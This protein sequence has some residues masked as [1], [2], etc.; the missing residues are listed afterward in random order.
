MAG[1]LP[2]RSSSLS[3]VS[4]SLAPGQS[5]ELEEVLEVEGKT[6]K[7]WVLLVSLHDFCRLK[8]LS[9]WNLFAFRCQVECEALSLQADLF[10]IPEKVLA[11]FWWKSAKPKPFSQKKHQTHG[12]MWLSSRPLA[13]L[14]LRVIQWVWS[15]CMLERWKAGS[16]S[17]LLFT[18]GGMS[19]TSQ[20]VGNGIFFAST[21]SYTCFIFSRFSVG[22]FGE[23]FF[24]LWKNI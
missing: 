4:P 6:T 7:T 9:H 22:L 11:N 16:W 5:F 12:S 2:S 23:S 3:A 15:M 1:L 10:C 8:H 21:V 17:P 24:L 18:R 20:V 14:Q 13:L 19:Y